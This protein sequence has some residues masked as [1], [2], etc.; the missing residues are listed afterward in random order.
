MKT[1]IIKSAYF[2]ILIMQFPLYFFNNFSFFNAWKHPQMLM[3]VLKLVPPRQGTTWRIRRHRFAAKQNKTKF[4]E[5][6]QNCEDTLQLISYLKSKLLRSLTTKEAASELISQFN[7]CGT[8]QQP[9]C[10]P[11]TVIL[12]GI[13]MNFIHV[14]FLQMIFT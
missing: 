6:K 4:F 14:W 9:W 5:W 8:I 11:K 13:E 3:I 12:P 1:G 2:F 7:N 10:Y